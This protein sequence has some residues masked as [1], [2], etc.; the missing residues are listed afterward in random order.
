MGQSSSV[1]VRTLHK[2]NGCWEK[3]KKVIQEKLFRLVVREKSE[4]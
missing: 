4:N 3:T 2:R 1:K